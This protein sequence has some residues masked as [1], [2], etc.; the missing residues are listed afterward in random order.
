MSNANSKERVEFYKIV[1]NVDG[2]LRSAMHHTL[3]PYNKSFIYSTKR[4]LSNLVFGFSLEKEAFVME[5]MKHIKFLFDAELWIADGTPA[6]PSNLL[7]YESKYIICLTV[8]SE[9]SYY[10]NV[11][12]L[13]RVL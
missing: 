13:R 6:L 11:K 3:E 4:R 12:L 9:S 10:K 7:F 8:C 2:K 5:Y 1:L